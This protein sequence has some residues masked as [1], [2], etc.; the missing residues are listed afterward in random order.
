[1]GDACHRVAAGLSDGELGR[2]RLT[3]MHGSDYHKMNGSSG[4]EKRVSEIGKLQNKESKMF[5]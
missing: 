2:V 5:R 3:P 1:M 4:R